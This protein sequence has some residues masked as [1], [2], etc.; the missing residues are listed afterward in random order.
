MQI[1]QEIRD[2]IYSYVFCSTRI[3]CGERAPTRIERIR[4]IPAPN[5]LALLRTCHRAHAEIGHRWLHELLFSFE[6]PV[7]ML[8]KL[9]NISIETRSMIRHVRVSGDPLMLTFPEDDVF[10]R[11][12]AALKLLPGLRLDRLTVMGTRTSMV[13]YETLNKLVGLSNGWKE[14]YYLSH[15]STFLGYED[16][17]WAW[18]DDLDPKLYLRMPQP[19]T[20]QQA[21]ED[22][23][24]SASCPS[25]AIYR[26][27]NPGRPCSVLHAALRAPFAQTLSAGQTLSTFYKKEDASLMAVGEREKEMLVVVKRGRGC[28][29]EEK[30]NSKYVPGDIRV[31]LP[32]MAWKQIRKK[33][34]GLGGDESDKEFVVP[35]WEKEKVVLEDAYSHVDDYVWPALH[36]LE[37]L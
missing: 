31:Q 33:F 8:D 27:T 23:D 30:Q 29:Y 14:L 21:L 25:V 3:C 22:R 2:I 28:D 20:W 4:I 11:T 37:D 9:S 17:W 5:A 12:H 15:N 16:T 19:A 13:S 36:Y 35:A 34:I 18:D 6:T 1:P 26:S 7:A 32:G 24:G 10:Y